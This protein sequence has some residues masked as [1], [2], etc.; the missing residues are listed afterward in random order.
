MYLSGDSALSLMTKEKFILLSLQEEKAKRLA[1]VISNE[2]C[3]KILDALADKDMT[4]TGLSKKLD[5]P[6]STVHYNLQ[7]LVKGGLVVCEEFHFS[8]KGK[9]VNHYKLASKYIIIA[10]KT[11]EGFAEKLKG[12]LP[13]V[14]VVGAAALALQWAKRFF[15]HAA[16]ATMQS[17]AMEAVPAPSMARAVGEGMADEAV[18]EL[19]RAAPDAI[20]AGARAMSAPDV[21]GA[22][23][24]ASPFQNIVLWFLVGAV[25][26]LLA[27]FFVQY[28]RKK[29]AAY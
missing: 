22:A 27:Y 12:L 26:A 16:A 5:V 14:G 6:I 10:P 21:A 29:R 13:V 18:Q 20:D 8:K 17:A 4:A 9:E 2:S 3:R 1:Q 28:L 23:M 24:Q 15:D 25:V 11:D 19:V 7:N